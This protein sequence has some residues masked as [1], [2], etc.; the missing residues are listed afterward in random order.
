MRAI[1]PFRQ[2]ETDVLKKT[3]AIGG[4]V[5]AT[6]TGALLT[7]SPASAVAPTWGHGGW[8]YGSHRSGLF[9][10]HRSFAANSNALF[11]RI[12]I[13]IHNR[14]NNV[15]I[16][17]QRQ[18]DRQRQFERQRSDDLGLTTALAGAPGAVGVPAVAPATAAQAPAVQAPA[19]STAR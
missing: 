10:S 7:S 19:A 9:H 13:R 15:A 12:R 3:C 16:N 6:A 8:G 5:I 11:N 2:K 17:N 4:L 18:R 14:N 1:V